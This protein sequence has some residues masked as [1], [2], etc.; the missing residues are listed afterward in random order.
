[1]ADVK[2]NA[3]KIT[4]LQNDVGALAG[5]MY[6]VEKKATQLEKEI[7]SMEENIANKPWMDDVNSVSAGL[8]K[9]I[10]ELQTMSIAGIALGAIALVL[11]VISMF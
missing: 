2:S 10:S 6:S 8:S 4:S 1:S 9:K 11:G 5:R 7:S 3:K